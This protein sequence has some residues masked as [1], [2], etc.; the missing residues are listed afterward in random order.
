[1]KKQM[2]KTVTRGLICLIILGMFLITLAPTITA[3]KAP[4]PK[5]PGISIQLYQGMNLITMPIENDYTAESLGQVIAG[6]TTVT[7]FNAESQTF[8]THVVGT[9]HDNFEIQNGVAYYVFVTDDTRII[10]TGE[11]I[12]SVNVEI[13]SGSNFVGCYSKEPV[14][15][16]VI[17]QSI[18]GCTVIIIFDHIIGQYITHVVGTPHDNFIIPPGTGVL[19]FSI[20]KGD[21]WTGYLL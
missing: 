20:T 11:V 7:M 4:R 9:P 21:V 19:A 18:P 8:L 3:K 15:A 2:K 17:G 10:L 12:K 5:I 13:F 16:E 1:M 6:C 14:S